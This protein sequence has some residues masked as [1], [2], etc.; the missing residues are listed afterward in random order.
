MTGRD[1]ER[2]PARSPSLIKP[3]RLHAGDRVAAVTL[4]WGGP[5]Q[6][7]QRYLA[8]KRQ[9]EEE[10]GVE[11]VEMDHTLAD[12]DWLHRHPEARAEDL[13]AAFA[14]ASVKGIISTIGGD[15]SIRILPYLDLRVIHDNPKVLMGFSDTTITHLACLKAGLTTFYGPAIMAGFAENGGLF[16]YMV[17]SVRRT[18]FELDP[19]GEVTPNTGGWTAEL[20]TWAVPENQNKRRSLNQSEGWKWLQGTGRHRGP[21]IGGCFEVFDWLRG[22]EYWPDAAW[23]DG[24]L[25]FLETSEEAPPPSLLG[26]TLRVYGAMGLLQRLGAILLARPGGEVAPADF[27]KYDQVLLEVV[28]DELGLTNLPVVAGMDLGHTDPVFVLPY[29]TMAEVDCDQ[30]RF[31]IVES[32]VTE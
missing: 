8:G 31:S 11:L 3:R 19:V 9:L 20:L 6:F 17:D 7:P 32:A 2:L 18:L 13:M 16:P 30:R 25:L 29:G 4:S 10:F 15:D 5:G 24:A 22:T 21:L 14:D 12:A 28:S 1:P 26:Y 27:C 23:W